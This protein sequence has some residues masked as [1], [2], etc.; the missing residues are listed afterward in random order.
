MKT[1]GHDVELYDIGEV[2]GLGEAAYYSVQTTPFVVV[3]RPDNTLTPDIDGAIEDAGLL[4]SCLQI[5]G[6]E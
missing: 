2:N 4:G 5:A 6:E 3:E 1:C